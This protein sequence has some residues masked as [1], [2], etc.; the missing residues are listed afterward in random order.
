MSGF[1]VF[2]ENIG[3][4]RCIILQKFSI[5]KFV[6]RFRLRMSSRCRLFRCFLGK[7]KEQSDEKG[8]F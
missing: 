4:I 5:F 6:K 7:R 8:C 3:R 1:A 2:G